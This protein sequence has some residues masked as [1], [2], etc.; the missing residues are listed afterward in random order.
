MKR[1]VRVFAILSILG[2]YICVTTSFAKNESP[3]SKVKNGIFHYYQNNGKFHSL[4]VRKDSLQTEINLN[5]NDTSYWR[6]QWI[7]ECAFTCKF[8]SSTK[9]MP[10]PE[11]EFYKSSSLKFNIMG[12]SKEYYLYNAVFTANNYSKV[13]NDT[14]WFRP[15]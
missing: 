3:C 11:Y 4:I 5:T 2:I 9:Q 14:I 6:I 12:T 7:S 10:K 8:I 15:K 1:V 13:L